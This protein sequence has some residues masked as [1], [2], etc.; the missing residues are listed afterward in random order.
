MSGIRSWVGVLF[1]LRSCN[2]ISGFRSW[3][4]WKPILEPQD[5]ARCFALVGA[6]IIAANPVDQAQLLQPGEVVVQR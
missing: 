3:L 2:S 5:V 6:R 1:F 4:W